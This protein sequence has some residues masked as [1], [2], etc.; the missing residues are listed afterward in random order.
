MNLTYYQV[1]AGLIPLH[2]NVSAL[3]KGRR[4]Q[5]LQLP[6]HVSAS[7]DR[8]INFSLFLLRLSV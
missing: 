3:Q 5:R 6:K 7:E 8:T 1:E 2:Y 4:S